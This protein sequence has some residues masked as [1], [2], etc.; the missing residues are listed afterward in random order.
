MI[1]NHK[2]TIKR[3]KKVYQEHIQMVGETIEISRN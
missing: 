3:K 2:Q 1:L